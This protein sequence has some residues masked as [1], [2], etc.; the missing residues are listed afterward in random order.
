MNSTSSP[1]VSN[2]PTIATIGF[3]ETSRIRIVSQ[4]SAKTV[5]LVLTV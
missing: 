4:M 2:V 1:F 5:F 3:I